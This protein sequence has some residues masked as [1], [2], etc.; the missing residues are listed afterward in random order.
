MK[1]IVAK[2]TMSTPDIPFER[3]TDLYAMFNDTR[4]S[5]QSLILVIEAVLNWKV[6]KTTTSRTILGFL[7]RAEMQLHALECI[8]KAD[9]AFGS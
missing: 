6:H 4:R 7:H 5:Q 1:S 9:V 3:R 2:V 8:V